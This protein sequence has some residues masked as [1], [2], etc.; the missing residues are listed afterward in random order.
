MVSDKKVAVITGASRGLGKAIA[1]KLAENGYQLALVARNENELNALAEQ[2]NEAYGV[3]VSCFKADLCKTSSA[4]HSCERI[5]HEFGQVDVLINNAGLGY[6]KPFLEHEI[7]ENDLIIDVNVKGP[8]HMCHS[9]L[10]SM[11]ERK[12]GQ[13]INIASDLSDRPLAN[14]AVY[15]ASK[16]A[17]RGFS[18][19]LLREFKDQGIKVT[20]V[21][22]G[23][24][25]TCFNG[26]EP[27]HQAAQ[28]ALQ[29][30]AV[31]DTIL[32][33]LNQPKHQIIDE[34]TLHP[35][36]QDF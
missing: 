1:Y 9:L 4:Y 3:K 19:S 27:G 30:E 11:V 18:L 22:P 20:L 2:L 34:I 36:H 17:L 13:I 25:D 12:S 24:I 31:A 26:N 29:P 15:A 33:L 21:N 32:Q 5:V 10:P 6:Y 8:I 7:Q 28:N 14:M 23:I 35:S 16:F